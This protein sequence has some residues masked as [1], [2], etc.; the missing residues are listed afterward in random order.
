MNEEQEDLQATP[1]LRLAADWPASVDYNEVLFDRTDDVVLL[2]LGF[3]YV[4]ST[5]MR[6]EVNGVTWYVD[7][8]AKRAPSWSY[9][10]HGRHHTP[11]RFGPM[12]YDTVKRLDKLST[13]LA[14]N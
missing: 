7:L 6:G 3:T 1:R 13:L 11:V 8:E 12:G 4:D 9:M 14:R 10:V 2:D 5:C